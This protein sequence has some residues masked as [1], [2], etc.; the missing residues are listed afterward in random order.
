M[1][2]DPATYLASISEIE[3]SNIDL[4]HAAIALAALAH[5][6]LVL[7]RYFH[8][9]E[10]LSTSV[11]ATFKSHMESGKPDDAQTRLEALC[12][13]LAQEHEYKG[14]DETYDDL[15]NANLIRVIER[16]KGLPI[17][18][19][20]LY[21]HAGRAQG[22]DVAGLNLP[23][24]F[25]CR[26]DHR[27]QRLIFD[28]FAKGK[29]LQAFDLRE[30]IKRFQGPQAELSADY[31]LQA[32]HRDILI[33]LQNNI[34][35]RQI[36]IED[37]PAALETVAHMRLFCP[38]DVRLLLEAGILYAKTGQSQAAIQT[39]ETY[40]GQVPFGR[41]RDEAAMLLQDIRANLN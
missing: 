2:F 17:T 10:K 20:I 24:H 41:E 21:M 25:V 6:G 11:K 19:A 15:Q 38:N 34:K 14:D 27:G 13:V 26:I 33:R 9:L 4:A 39:L 31:F 16:R 18:L 30:I 22:W 12:A 35:F 5:P 29:V 3:D 32:N 1:S 23:G 40:I 28:P 37:Y 36:Q 8:H 7:D